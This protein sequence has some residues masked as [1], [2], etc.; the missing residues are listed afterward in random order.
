[1]EIFFLS[2][3][4]RLLATCTAAVVPISQFLTTTWRIKVQKPA[5]RFSPPVHWRT[6]FCLPHV[7]VHTNTV[8]CENI[9]PLPTSLERPTSFVVLSS[10]RPSIDVYISSFV[11]AKS[12]DF[13]S[14]WHSNTSRG[15]SLCRAVIWSLSLSP[16]ATAALCGRTLKP[17]Q[18]SPHPRATVWLRLAQ[19]CSQLQIIGQ[20][21]NVRHSCF[22]ADNRLWLCFGVGTTTESPNC[23]LLFLSV[24][25]LF[26][27][28]SK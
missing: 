20:K 22:M 9:F 5:F 11:V 21:Y 27:T 19:A 16:V 17:I 14:A 3:F 18:A 28:K 15:L 10:Q 4:F 1:M 23:S 24:C 13:I 26:A 25:L 7:T 2:L 8:I 12:S 6:F